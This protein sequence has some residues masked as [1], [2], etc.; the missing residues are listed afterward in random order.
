MPFTVKGQIKHHFSSEKE[1][2]RK[3]RKILCHGTFLGMSC[4]PQGTFVGI[5]CSD[6]NFFL[7]SN[8]ACKDYGLC[9]RNLPSGFRGVNHRDR[10]HCNGSTPAAKPCAPLLAVLRGIN[11][12]DRMPCNGSTLAASDRG[13]HN[14]PAP[15]N[16][17]ITSASAAGSRFISAMVS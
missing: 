8:C 16:A 6:L 3:L 11:R 4:V 12:R 13:Y 2:S 15:V 1:N 17:S 9:K 5:L 7:T 10:L 14:K